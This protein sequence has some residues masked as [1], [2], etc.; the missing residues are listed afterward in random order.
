[1]SQAYSSEYSLHF[2]LQISFLEVLRKVF[3]CFFLNTH[4]QADGQGFCC[5]RN[6]TRQY[7]IDRLSVHKSLLPAD[8]RLSPSNYLTACESGESMSR[9]A[10]WLSQPAPKSRGGSGAL[11]WAQQPSFSHGR[12]WSL[13]FQPAGCGRT[14]CLPSM[15][16]SSWWT[17]QITPGLWNPKL[18]LM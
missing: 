11:L 8:K 3:L 12:C 13:A 1:M 7:C 5:N 9:T 15:G 16:S 4:K 2:Y 6:S 14:T 18:S 10:G 17:V